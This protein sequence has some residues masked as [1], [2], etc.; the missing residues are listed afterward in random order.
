[1]CKCKGTTV[2]GKTAA[3]VGALRHSRGCH[4]S[5]WCDEPISYAGFRDDEAWI[6]GIILNFFA[7]MTDVN[8]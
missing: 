4:I 8:S 1:M 6:G 5:V 2:I 7:K 3:V